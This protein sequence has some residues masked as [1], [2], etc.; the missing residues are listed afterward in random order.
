MVLYV[1][2]QEFAAI[3]GIIERQTCEKE[4]T[5]KEKGGEEPA[6]QAN[7]AAVRMCPEEQ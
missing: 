1:G 2:Y 6:S 4:G 3:I 7:Q 5:E